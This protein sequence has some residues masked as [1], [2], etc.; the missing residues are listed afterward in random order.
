MDCYILLTVWWIFPSE[1]V[2][3]FLFV[4]YVSATVGSPGWGERALWPPPPPPTEVWSAW[5]SKR[6]KTKNRDTLTHTPW[7]DKP[8][9]TVPHMLLT[10]PHLDP[11]SLPWG[12]SVKVQ[13][14]ICDRWPSSRSFSHLLRSLFCSVPLP[15]TQ[16]NRHTHTHTLLEAFGASVQHI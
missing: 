8:K 10:S 6:K 3:V 12:G 5:W 11:E 1:H 15:P 16:T 4:L 9:L 13:G 7:T 2:S 14:C